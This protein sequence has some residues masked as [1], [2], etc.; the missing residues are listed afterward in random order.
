M[1]GYSHST[2]IFHALYSATEVREIPSLNVLNDEY[3]KYHRKGVGEDELAS[4]DK[5]RLHLSSS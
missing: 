4:C 3:Q 5:N 1:L 2:H